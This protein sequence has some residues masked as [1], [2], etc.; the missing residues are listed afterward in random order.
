MKIILAS[1]SPRRIKLLKKIFSKFDVIPSFFDESRIRETRPI[2]FAKKEAQAK[3]E[4]V[5]KS[6]KENALIIAAD[7]IVIFEGRI[8]GKPKNDKDAFNILNKLAGQEQSVVTAFCLINTKVKQKIVDFERSIVK[9]R[10]VPSQQLRAY[11]ASGEGSDKAGAYAVQGRA[12][13]FIE[14][15]KG[16]YYNI[17]GLPVD[18]LKKAINNHWPDEFS[19]K[20]K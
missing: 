1:Q 18:K 5:A 4:Q 8:I 17:I 12:D 16:D 9:M 3:A 20:E 11:V 19:F 13:K 2:E 15:T 7:T 14:Y 6:I 10:Q